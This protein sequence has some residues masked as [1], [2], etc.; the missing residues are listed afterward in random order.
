MKR[1]VVSSLTAAC[2]MLLATTAHASYVERSFHNDPRWKTQEEVDATKE[3]RIDARTT[4]PN[5]E[6]TREQTTEQRNDFNGT[7]NTDATKEFGDTLTETDI[8]TIA[9]LTRAEFTAMLVR[10]EYSQAS[11]DDCYWDITSVWPPRFE[12]LFR[13]VPVDHK[14]APE[15][16]VAMRD[17][18]VRGYGNDVFRP[19]API[20]FADAAKISA[21]SYG[22]TPWAD[23]NQPKHWFDTYVY[24]L[25]EHNAIPTSIA[26][27][28]DKLTTEQAH[29][30]LERLSIGDRTRPSRNADVLIAAWEKKYEA[31][32]RA[33]VRTTTVTTSSATSSASVTPP[34]PAQPAVA[35]AKPKPAPATSSAAATGSSSS[36]AKAWYEF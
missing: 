32:R 29:E 34:T 15:I 19:D 12:L 27:I 13:D 2:G 25:S 8:S 28:D 11:I 7:T 30:M 31:P 4:L 20:T 6:A 21:R 23:Q 22:L 17:G 10:A 9:P 16:C 26:S 1:F 36:R 35:P 5:N 24:A 18:L 3:L 14:F 33:V